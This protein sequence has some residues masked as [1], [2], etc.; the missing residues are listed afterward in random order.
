M[1][2]RCAGLRPGQPTRPSDL[3]LDGLALLITDGY[4]SGTAVLKEA[5]TR[6]QSDEV[7]A[8][9]RLRWSLL[10]G[11]A[12]GVIWDYD[13]WDVLTAGHERLARDVGGSSPPSRSAPRS[14]CASSRETLPR[15]HC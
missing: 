5:L 13:A 8:E 10:A 12:A 11:G 15:R 6:F 4:K 14:G 2:E 7:T 3:L 9:E 1:A